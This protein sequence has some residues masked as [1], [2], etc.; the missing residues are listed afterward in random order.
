MAH[1]YSLMLLN[2][3]ARVMQRPPGRFFV[4][5]VY[6]KCVR[7]YAVISISAL[8]AARKPGNCLIEFL[9]AVFALIFA[10]TDNAAADMIFQQKQT[11]ALHG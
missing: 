10:G 7:T 8:N 6:G 1:G 4:F 2:K 9:Q 5:P 11:N 3:I